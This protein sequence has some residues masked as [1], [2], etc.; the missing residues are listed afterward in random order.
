MTRLQG[1]PPRLDE[2]EGRRAAWGRGSP[3]L[4]T[5]LLI[6][7]MEEAMRLTRLFGPR[8]R[9]ERGN[10][11]VEMA[12][13]MPV[14]LF[15]VAGALDLG[16]L[17]WVK[18]VITNASREGARAAANAVDTGTAVNANLTQTQVKQVVQTYL[19]QFALKKL[20]GTSLTLDGSTFS[21]TWAATASGTVLTVALNQ[22][23]CKMNLL[24]NIKTLFGGSRSAGDDAFYLN[25]QTSMAAQWTTPPGP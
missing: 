7:E 3:G 10:L 17:F 11:T 14:F 2:P 15:M 21:Y 24:P 12:L 8:R 9:R 18:H 23:P 19:N 20:D 22:I 16:M 6:P 25:A 13:A 1:P 5:W 4:T